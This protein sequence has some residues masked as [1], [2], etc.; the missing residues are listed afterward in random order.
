MSGESIAFLISGI[1]CALGLVGAILGYGW[2]R[3]HPYT[4]GD[5]ERSNWFTRWI[6][7]NFNLFMWL[8]ILIILLMTITFFVMFSAS[9]K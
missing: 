7:S 1:V 9:L 5:L 8:I 3:Q 6:R 4:L 2:R